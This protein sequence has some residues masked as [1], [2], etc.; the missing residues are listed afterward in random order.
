MNTDTIPEENLTIFCILFKIENALREFIIHSL[1]ESSGPKW[2]LNRLPGDILTKYRNARQIELGMSW[3][4][5]IP[6]HPIY[7]IDF[8]D[9]LKIIVPSDNWSDQFERVF[10]KKD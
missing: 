2:Y 8:P 10:A 1:E 4:T 3:S 6:H 5:L 7:Y 9:L